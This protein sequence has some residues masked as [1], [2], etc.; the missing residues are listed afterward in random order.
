MIMTTF[1]IVS[2]LL[3]ALLGR[4]FN[5]FVLVPAMLLGV[6]LSVG[7]AAV[8]GISIWET[9][10]T[11]GLS[12]AGLQV[13]FVANCV[14]PVTDAQML[15]YTDDVVKVGAS[16]QPQDEELEAARQQLDDTVPELMALSKQMAGRSAAANAE[17]A[18]RAAAIASGSIR[19]K[20]S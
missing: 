20:A 1:V 11:L 8:V 4:R 5:V 2:T 3:G 14:I 6:L 19:S 15:E 7:L 17:A 12:M 16:A 10:P 18:D 13:G 9:L